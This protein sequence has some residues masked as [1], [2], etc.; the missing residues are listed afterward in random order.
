MKTTQNEFGGYDYICSK[1]IVR[2]CTQGDERRVVVFTSNHL[3]DWHAAFTLATPQ[4]VV[5]K[6]R[7]AALAQFGWYPTTRADG[8]RVFVSI[9]E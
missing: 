9:P 6:V 8:R 3:I 2:T 4:E 5:D 7:D 1:G